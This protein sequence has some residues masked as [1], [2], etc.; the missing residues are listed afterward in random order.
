MAD[1]RL[2][3][4]LN[5]AR[6]AA[7]KCADQTMIRELGV[8]SSQL[9]V[10]YFLRKN[11]GC[12]LKELSEGL[13]LNNSAITGLA[14]R[15]EA[16]DLVERRADEADG[17]AFRLFLSPLGR[18][19]AEASLPLLKELNARIEKDFSAAE[20]ETVA[21][22]LETVVERL[23]PRPGKTPSNKALIKR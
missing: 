10:L 17:R 2:F 1:K 15:M 5:R 11:D 13:G 20:L 16:I 9:G 8:T 14:D 4:L 19:R 18:A 6:H 12:L 3:F 22:F 7:L 23:G 21:R